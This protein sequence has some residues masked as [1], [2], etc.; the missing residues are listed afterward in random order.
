MQEISLEKGKTQTYKPQVIAAAAVLAI[1]ASVIIL[2]WPF[3]IQRPINTSGKPEI[4]FKG[5]VI[6]QNALYKD[7]EAYI[8]LE[9]IEA[10]L[11]PDIQYDKE[12]GMVIITTTKNVFHFPLGAKTGLSNLEPYTF[13]YPVIEED[14]SIYLPL[15]PLIDYYEL[16][17][18]ED[19]DRMILRFQD[20]KEPY[21]VGQVIKDTKLRHS[22]ALRSPWAAEV[23]KGEN[24]KVL[25]EKD[26]WYWVESEDG[27]MGYIAESLL[28]LTD[29]EKKEIKKEVYQPWNPIGEP[30]I[31]TWE[32]AGRT[33]VN[34]YQLKGLNGV[35]VLSPTW[36]HLQ[37]DGV[38]INN[39]DMRYVKW[40]HDQGRQV[41]GLFDN[42]FDPDLTH[43]FLND[44][45]LRIKAVK[46]LLSYID[47]YKL[48]GINIDFE[49]MYLQ[50]KDSFTQFIRELAPLLH[51]KERTLSVDVTF[52]SMSET[53]SMCYD[54][55][56]LAKAADYLM[57]MAYDEHGGSGKTAGSTASLPWV[58]R[59]IVRML[60]EVPEEKLILG[61]PFYTRLWTEE[62]D[63]NGKK[64]ITSKAFSMGKAEEWIKER[65]AAILYDEKTGQNYVQVTDDNTIYKMWL[66]DEVS[67]KKRIE[68]MRKYRLAGA[69][70]WRRGLEKEEAWTVIN[71]VTDSRI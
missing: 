20:L 55:A 54:R 25:R 53:W 31:L 69:G 33:T 32:Y 28:T 16:E 22:S 5:E 24:V 29:I 19:R 4:Y 70:A 39:A 34:P 43:T 60:E 14:G 13:T 7:Q 15:T 51:E 38:V 45:N 17:V 12:N 1:V 49:N 68:L 2:F 21:Q 42:G 56:S 44:S 11:D 57:V 47:M 64:S 67:L 52:H 26:N 63:S 48:D 65:N 40:A 71:E 66:E 50:D 8:P 62:T 46:Q 23:M 37:N 35:Q 30:I 36:F 59:G 58:E 10:H 18:I 27:R 61:I 6:S 3:F 41:W 9:F